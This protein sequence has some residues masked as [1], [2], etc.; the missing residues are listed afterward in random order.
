M[1]RVRAFWL[2]LPCSSTA[3]TPNLVELARQCLGAVL[4][5]GEHH[6]PAG[7]AGQVDQDRQPVLA[8]HMEDMVGHRR[9]RRLRRVGLVRHRVDQELLDDAVDRVVERGR[10]QHP[11]TGPRGL[12]EQALHRRQEAQVGHVVGLVKHGDLD[13]AE[14]AVPLLDE[15]LESAGTGDDDVDALAESLDLR[16]LADATEDGAGAQ[17]VGFRQWGK[18]FRDLSDELT[19]RRQDEGTWSPGCRASV[20]R[21]EPGDDR[22]QERVGLAG[23]G[24]ATA[25]KVAAGQ[26]V[27][28]GR[29]LD[30]S[31]G[32]DAQVRQY[33]GELRGHAEID[34][35]GGR[36]ES[37]AISWCVSPS[38]SRRRREWKAC[39]RG[40]ARG[41]G[42]ELR[43]QPEARLDGLL[44]TTIGHRPD[45]SC[46]IGTSGR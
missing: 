18:G 6:G 2:R 4:G 10:E 40:V 33:G 43:R 34:E 25:E 38:R 1:L 35:G 12:A 11:L 20:A 15:V 45:I 27:G 26:G 9:D 3:V 41:A 31:G 21:G 13:R 16:V 19:G 29:G 46:I 28:Q 32:L 30:G 44:S 42:V 17:A 8:V 22:E 36:Q 37:V 5:A 23:A 24:A 39:A 7:G 14:S